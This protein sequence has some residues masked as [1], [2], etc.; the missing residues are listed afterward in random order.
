M[1]TNIFKNYKKSYNSF[2]PFYYSKTI[3]TKK[4]NGNSSKMAKE[5]NNSKKK[6]KNNL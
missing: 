3:N 1:K 5:S 6:Y 4:I 2:N